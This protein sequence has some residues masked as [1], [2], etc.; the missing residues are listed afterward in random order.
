MNLQLI[1]KSLKTI[2]LKLSENKKNKPLFNTKQYT[3]N[4]ENGLQ[5]AYDLYFNGERPKNIFLK[6]FQ[7]L[8]LDI[9]FIINFFIWVNLIF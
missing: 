9:L 2:S 4:F 6:E 7:K 8:C 1:L 3:N 5:K